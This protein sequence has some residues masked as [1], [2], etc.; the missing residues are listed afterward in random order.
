MRN[1]STMGSRTRTAYG[2]VSDG[3]QAF[4]R[5]RIWESAI[6]PGACGLAQ[7][8]ARQTTDLWVEA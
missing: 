4:L 2:V 3:Q 7:G 8:S 6:L 1:A 5:L